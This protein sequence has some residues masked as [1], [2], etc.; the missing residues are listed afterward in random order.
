MM[1]N[2]QQA[3][4]TRTSENPVHDL[5][6]YVHERPAL[7]A[8]VGTCYRRGAYNPHQVSLHREMEKLLKV[9]EDVNPCSNA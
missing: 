6:G 4:T 3:C 1:R 7:A 8:D 9:E 5:D 2:R